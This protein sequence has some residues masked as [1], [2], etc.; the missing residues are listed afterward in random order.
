[1]A[2]RLLGSLARTP[3]ALVVTLLL[4]Y[5]QRRTYR[6]LMALDD[7]LLKDVGLRRDQIA[8]VAF[9]GWR[10]AGEATPSALHRLVETH[11]TQAHHAMAGNDADE[12]A[13]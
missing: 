3:R 1:V 7:H 9:K 6:L 10:P 8:K 12:E 11:A 5:R 13:A 2:W 4:S